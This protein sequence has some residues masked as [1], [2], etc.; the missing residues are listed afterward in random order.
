M[1][2]FSRLVKERTE[3]RRRRRRKLENITRCVLTSLLFFFR[4]S[5]FVFVMRALAS[6]AES[7]SKLL[8][9]VCVGSASGPLHS[10]VRGSPRENTW[11]TMFL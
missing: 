2:F 4:F 8:Y 7:L 11:K 6:Y 1:N 9:I 5:T 3:F 10:E